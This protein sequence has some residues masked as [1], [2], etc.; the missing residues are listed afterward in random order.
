MYYN[1]HDVR[2]EEM[3]KP[4]ISPDEFL[5]KVIASG[6]C[7][8]DVLE[9]YRIKTAPR[10]L[11]HEM[12]GEIVETGKNVK[13]YKK[14][15]RVFVT[16]HVPCNTCH[17][18][19]NGHHT[20]CE[21]LHHTNYDPGGFA[22]FIRIPQINIDRGT[23]LLPDNMSYEVATFIEPLGCVARGQRLAQMCMGSTV[24]IIGSG[25]SGLLHLKLAKVMGAGKIIATD[26]NKYRLTKA[27]EFGADE[28]IDAGENVPERL[29]SINEGNLADFVIVCAGAKNA[30][31][32]ALKCIAPGGTIL[33]FAV[34]EPGV[35][36]PVPISE[37][38]RNEVKMMTSYGAAPDDLNTALELLKTRSVKVEDMITHRLLLE[39]TARGFQL[40]ANSG[41]SLK[42]IINP[43][44]EAM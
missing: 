31:I 38:W 4:K 36:I 2:L 29:L 14:G 28:V 35:D 15:E 13:K 25:I 22:E 16:H 26:I 18:C 20:A 32:Q 23:F 7:G 34:P 3:P 41:E 42:V 12:A 10:V 40:V 17:F 27:K 5:V 33:F 19:L 39:Q 43:A 11:G 37:L 24:L 9:W 30:C 8:T 21:T 6:I 1:N 44:Q